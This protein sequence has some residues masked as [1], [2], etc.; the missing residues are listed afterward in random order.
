MKITKKITAAVCAI[1]LLALAIPGTVQS[2]GLKGFLKGVGQSVLNEGKNMGQSLIQEAKQAGE[3]ALGN[4]LGGNTT[5]SNQNSAS[6]AEVT[7]NSANMS[8]E[9]TSTQSTKTTKQTAAKSSSSSK[10]KTSTGSTGPTKQEATAAGS[11]TALLLDNITMNN[12]MF[13]LTKDANIILDKQGI[14]IEG[15]VTVNVK[16][17]RGDRILCFI[18]PIVD[19]NCFEDDKGD[20]EILVAFTPNSD[21]STV[22]VPFAIP[23]SWLGIDMSNK[24]DKPKSWQVQVQ[25]MDLT[26][27]NDIAW[28]LFDIQPENV[29]INQQDLPMHMVESLF[30]G[31]ADGDLTHT[32][33]AC[34][35]SGLCAECYGDAY[36]KPSICR[37]CSDSPGICRRCKGIGEEGT[38]I[39]GGSG[40]FFDL[41]F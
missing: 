30:R 27:S 19:G 7:V 13:R 32:C 36:L 29:Q 10:K 28:A 20:C 18:K 2:K 23:Y 16:N 5:E 38:N 9:S 3:Q 1:A 35:G 14:S 25:V 33:T 12:P 21:S 17:H 31:S 34:D 6:D 24:T 39:S 8:S 15:Y 37:R 11:V 40:D 26:D 41:I 22:N 4:V